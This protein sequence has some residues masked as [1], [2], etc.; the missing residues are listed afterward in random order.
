MSTFLNNRA[1]AHCDT[2]S[3]FDRFAEQIDES[4]EE[5]NVLHGGPHLRCE[6][7]PNTVAVYKELYPRI[8]LELEFDDV[9]GTVRMRRQKLEHPSS[10]HAGALVSDLRVRVDEKSG[11]SVDRVD[12]CRLA[13][14][15]LRPLMEAFE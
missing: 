13:R 10:D 3:I 4:V 15:A 6:R 8:T 12:Y 9:A 11:G 1:A 2:K 5:F 14:Q 7:T